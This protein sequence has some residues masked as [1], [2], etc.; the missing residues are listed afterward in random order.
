M[1]V[2]LGYKNVFRDPRGYPEWSSRGLP[3]GKAPTELSESAVKSGEDGLV[4]DNTIIQS[5]TT[6]VG[7][8]TSC[9]CILPRRP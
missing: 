3:T 6:V 4:F 2:K 8:I 9:G 5:P 7:D 1:A